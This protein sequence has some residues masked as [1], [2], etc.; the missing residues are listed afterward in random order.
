ME[1]GRAQGVGA[2]GGN[3]GPEVAPTAEHLNMEN[4][5]TVLQIAGNNSNFDDKQ[6]TVLQK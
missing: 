3:G 2:P 6:S 4:A 1:I 5:V